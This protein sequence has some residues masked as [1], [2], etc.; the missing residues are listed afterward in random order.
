MK[1]RITINGKHLAT[2]EVLGKGHLG[3]HI[4][5][6]DK[7]GTGRP[8]MDISIGGYDTNDPEETKYLKW[9]GAALDV[10]SNVKIEIMPDVPADTPSNIKSSLKD[11]KVITTT[12]EQADRILKAS[13]ACNEILNELL[14]GLR[15]ELSD[16]DYKKVAY[17]VG[18]VI[19]EV[20]SSIAEPVYRK[21]PDKVPE[22]LKNMPL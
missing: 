21:H 3:A 8:K 9:P 12:G 20:F 17:G 14:Q 1:I 13:Y 22:A 10:G 18:S 6:N 5:L 19:N 7:T 11:K 15:N 16:S 4:N 2:S